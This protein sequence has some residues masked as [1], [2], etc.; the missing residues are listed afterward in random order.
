LRNGT[1]WFRRRVPL[2]YCVIEPREII[3]VSLH[4]DSAAEADREAAVI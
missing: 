3:I 2:R 1:Y 4:T